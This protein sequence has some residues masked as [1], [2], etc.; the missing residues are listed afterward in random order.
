M[1]KE[2]LFVLTIDKLKRYGAKVDEGMARC[3]NNEAIYFR[4][5]GMAVEDSAFEKLENG[6]KNGDLDAAFAAAHTLKG[7]LGNLS[8]EPMYRPVTELTELLRHK[9]PG[10]YEAYLQTIKT[11]RAA[12]QTLIRN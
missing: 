3:L 12:L 1:Q 6:L 2:V 9:T 4:L 7:S 8:L 11:Q 5:I 10:D